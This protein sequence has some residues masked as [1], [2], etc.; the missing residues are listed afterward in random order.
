MRIRF[1]TATDKE[2]AE[3]LVKN[4]MAPYYQTRGIEW[5]SHRYQISWK[6]FD[7]YEVLVGDIRVGVARFTYDDA[8]TYIRDLQI[9]P[10]HQ[11]QGLGSECF[12]HIKTRA[13]Q[14]GSSRIILRAFEENPA[15][16]LYRYLGYRKI[17]A[18]Q[19]LIE[20]QLLL[21]NEHIKPPSL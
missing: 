1:Q 7:N 18:G 15:I 21:E 11:G 6:E 12:S 14:R 17:R 2:Y 4:N 3:H 9:E 19:G 20:M 16:K 13:I 10:I 5:D 8:T